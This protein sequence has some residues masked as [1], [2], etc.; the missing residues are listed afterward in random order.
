MSVNSQTLYRGPMPRFPLVRAFALG[1]C[2]VLPVALYAVGDLADAFPGVLTVQ[3]IQDPRA[4]LPPAEIEDS[5]PVAVP[6]LAPEPA[7]SVT[8]DTSALEAR[9][10]ET[11]GLPVVSGRLSV[12]VIDAA[13]GTELASRDAATPRVPAST[14]KLLTA[15][16][17]LQVRDGSDT[18]TTRAVLQDGTLTLVGGGDMMLTREKLGELADGAVRL[19]EQQGTERVRLVLDDSLI[20]G[21]ANPAWGDNGQQGGWVAPTAAL[22]VDEG[23][24]DDQQYGPKSAQPAQDAARIFADL[25][26]ERGLTV[27]R[28]ADGTIP[29]GTAPA[30]PAAEVAV[31]SPTISEIVEH[32]LTISDNTTAELLAHL[33]AL[34]HGQEATP[35]NAAAAVAAEV[36]ALGEDIGVPG[37]DLEGLVIRDGSGLSVDNR[38]SPRLLARVIAAAASGQREDLAP[39]LT[40]V[41]IAH[42]TGTLADRFNA[43]AVAA[44]RGV[45]RGKTGYLGGAATLAGVTVTADGRTVAFSIVVHGFDG[46]DAV[47]ARAAVDRAAAAI[48]E[49]A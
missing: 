27:E 9:L 8:T 22:A 44:A 41:P 35:G 30:D 31:Q 48:V 47:A 24:L 5:S 11:A 18:L 13:S 16:A 29:R 28:G 3:R 6:Q 32:T 34:A 12:E 40:Q 20:P 4:Q 25:L 38:V 21:G 10:E 39:L 37:E 15:A 46:A 14:L 43:D 17:V 45:V 2:A 7:A 42:L 26:E 19:A 36:R 33:V 1:M 49:T 23:W